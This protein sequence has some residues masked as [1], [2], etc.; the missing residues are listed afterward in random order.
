MGYSNFKDRAFRP[1]IVCPLSQEMKDVV[2]I[3]AGDTFLPISHD[4]PCMSKVLIRK[5]VG[6]EIGET[7]HLNV[8]GNGKPAKWEHDLSC[9]DVEMSKAMT[10]KMAKLYDGTDLSDNYYWREGAKRIERKCI[11]D[12]SKYTDIASAR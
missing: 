10:T 7:L 11:E 6:L 2:R 12:E 5:M 1:H 4:L 9:F 8:R 3:A